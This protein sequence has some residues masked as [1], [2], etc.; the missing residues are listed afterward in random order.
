M[1][2]PFFCYSDNNTCSDGSTRT[3][4]PQGGGALDDLINRLEIQK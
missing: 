4:S 3:P 1:P 2:R